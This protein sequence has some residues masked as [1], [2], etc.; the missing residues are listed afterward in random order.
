MRTRLAAGRRPVLA[1]LLLW[2]AVLGGAAAWTAHLLAGWGLE[3]IVCS[4]VSGST[5][6]LGAPL[7]PVIG[8]ITAALAVVALAALLVAFTVWRRGRGA[9]IE[10]AAAQTAGAEEPGEVAR[11]ERLAFMGLVGLLADLLFLAIIVYGGVALIFLGP[12]SH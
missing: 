11:L 6:L 4:P 1:S 8:G 3:E 12:C 9:A 10:A 2:F 7:V 5:E